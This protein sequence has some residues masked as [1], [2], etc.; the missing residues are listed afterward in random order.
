MLDCILLS[1]LNLSAEL[2]SE[3]FKILLILDHFLLYNVKVGQELATHLIGSFKSL[4]PVKN[5][6]KLLLVH[7]ILGSH[8]QVILVLKQLLSPKSQHFH[9]SFLIHSVLHSSV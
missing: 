1:G 5:I 6:S 9:Y 3:I 7:N 8:L 4:F 2:Q